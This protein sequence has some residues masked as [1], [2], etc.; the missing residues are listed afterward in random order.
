[1]KTIK[2]GT[3]FQVLDL[4]AEGLIVVIEADGNTYQSRIHED[5]VVTSR[6]RVAAGEVSMLNTALIDQ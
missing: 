3:Q 1:M 5:E 4:G 6:R 2:A